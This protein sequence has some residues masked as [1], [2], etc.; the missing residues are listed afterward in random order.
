MVNSTRVVFGKHRLGHIFP[1][2]M[3]LREADNA[4]VG[5]IQQL[6]CDSHF[7]LFYSKSM[8][9]VGASEESLSM[10]GVCARTVC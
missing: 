4:F 9:V 7:I 1:M 8:H 3:S 10:M 5:A 2:V 6:N